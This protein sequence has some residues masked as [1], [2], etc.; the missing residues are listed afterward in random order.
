MI[1]DRSSC[2]HG[3]RPRSA[4][5]KR[6]AQRSGKRPACQECQN[7][8]LA[9][10]GVVT[11]GR[12]MPPASKPSTTMPVSGPAPRLAA[13]N[14]TPPVTELVVGPPAAVAG[15]GALP[16]SGGRHIPYVPAH[17]YVP[18]WHGTPLVDTDSVLAV[19]QS[20]HVPAGGVAPDSQVS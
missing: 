11:R 4:Q 16:A 3:Q 15:E 8:A 19:P 20:F 2:S 6:L 12:R 14:A 1:I 10:P 7:A 17:T 9:F 18:G 5:V 13:V